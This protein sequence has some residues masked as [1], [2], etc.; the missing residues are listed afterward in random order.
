MGQ[1]RL[2]LL[3]LSNVKRSGNFP[4]TICHACY[5]AE[6]Q[7]VR[8]NNRHR[9]LRK[10]NPGAGRI[11]VNEWLACLER[12]DYSCAACGCSGRKKLT[13]DHKVSLGSGGTNL[14]ENIQPLCAGCHVV[15]D[16]HQ[17]HFFWFIKRPYRR[18]RRWMR[19]R[20][21]VHLPNFFGKTL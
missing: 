8:S 5:H 20:F 21:G 4:E 13:M 18:F 16:G 19:L 7:R 2:C 10:K 11:Y 17:R 12:H 6:R 1:C 15:K 14:V 9:R 3:S